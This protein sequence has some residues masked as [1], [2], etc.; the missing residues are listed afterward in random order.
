MKGL[1]I[2]R[3]AIGVAFFFVQTGDDV[4]LDPESGPASC[5]LAFAD[6]DSIAEGS[7]RNGG[8]ADERRT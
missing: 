4:S 3:I 6:R 2:E 5:L 8:V 7:R 1:R